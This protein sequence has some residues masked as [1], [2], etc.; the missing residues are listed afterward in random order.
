MVALFIT[1]Y[2]LLNVLIGIYAARRVKTDQDFIL[3]GRRLSLP[4]AAATVFATWFG[5]ETVL[6][7]SSRF[8]EEGGSGLVE[9]PLGAAL[10]LV[11]VGFFFAR[12]L[13]RM[14]LN[15][16]GDFY[17]IRFGKTAELI[18]GAVL[19]IS[20]VGWVS[21]QMVAMGLVLHTVVP[22]ISVTA[23]I[24]LSTAVVVGYTMSGGMWSVSLTDFVQTIF[25]V[26]GLIA[27]TLVVVSQ[28]GGMEAVLHAAPE[29]SFNLLPDK[30]FTGVLEFVAAWIS[31]G[32]GSI[33]QQDVFQRVMASKSE[34]V[35]V[36]S[37]FLAAGMYLTI[38][39]LPIVMVLAAK[40]LIT[41]PAD[42]QLT[43]PTLI[44]Q[45]TGPVLQ[46]FFFGALLSA[47]MST[48]SGALLAPAVILSENILQPLFPQH[49]DRIRLLRTRLCV[50]ALALVAVGMAIFRRDIA[51]L[52]SE[53][54]AISLVGLF[55][56]LC[57][58]LFLRSTNSTAAITS[59]LAG[60]GVWFVFTLF[61]NICP[62]MIW[63]IAASASGW[64]AVVFIQRMKS[65]S[66]Q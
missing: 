4:L 33:P 41:A 15:T 54:S 30:S 37:S 20:Y 57:S 3:A 16:F 53:A 40:L 27:A 42:V 56:P 13:Y 65:M 39:F 63:G 50:A 55:V 43:L 9:D 6:G 36:Q 47:V 44:M 8:A 31:I 19:V 23:G 29:N 46:I 12:P 64:L 24:L 26:A 51:E 11:L 10:C 38:A 49:S 52:V 17:R 22:E 48:A 59:M 61:P 66:Q 34:K 5:S 62:A 28:A 21:A 32:L 35:A 18:A 45:Q 7:A 60:M 1:G 58:G 14:N 2:L 25:I